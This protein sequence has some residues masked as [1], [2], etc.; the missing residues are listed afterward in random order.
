MTG[1][2][3]REGRKQLDGLK[4]CDLSAAING[5]L[6]CLSHNEHVHCPTVQLTGT[7]VA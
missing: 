7:D 2:D 4:L 5:S 6:R 1:V 3:S